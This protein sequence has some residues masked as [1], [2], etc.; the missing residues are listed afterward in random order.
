[1][2]NPTLERMRGFLKTQKR[3]ARFFILERNAATVAT[4]ILGVVLFPFVCYYG[5]KQ[6][7]RKWTITNEEITVQLENHRMWGGTK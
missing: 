4:G 3:K 6:M 7:P 5:F 2:K 1:M